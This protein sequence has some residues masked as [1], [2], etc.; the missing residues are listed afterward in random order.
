[1][2]L[3]FG[4][5]LGAIETKLGK[6]DLAFLKLRDVSPNI[7][8]ERLQSHQEQEVFEAMLSYHVTMLAYVVVSLIVLSSRVEPF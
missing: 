6:M 2:L 1:M 8:G 4:V 3:C 5:F 7:K